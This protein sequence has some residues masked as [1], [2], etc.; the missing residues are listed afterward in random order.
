VCVCVLNMRP[1]FCNPSQICRV[2]HA[3]TPSEAHLLVPALRTTNKSMLSGLVN[4]KISTL[5]WVFTCDFGVS[6]APRQSAEVMQ[7]CSARKC[8]LL[9]EIRLR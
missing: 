4:A 7:C 5:L 3:H 2:S 6:N 9:E 1:H 8:D